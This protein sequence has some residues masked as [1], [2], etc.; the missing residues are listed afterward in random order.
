M[1]EGDLVI[2]IGNTLRGD[3]GVGWWLAERLEGQRPAA[4]EG[5]GPSI[6]GSAAV[7]GWPQVRTV[8]QLTPELAEELQAVRRVLFIDAWWPPADDS[9]GQ[10]D[11]RTDGTSPAAMGEPPEASGTRLI[12]TP[13][14]P[15]GGSGVAWIGPVLERLTPP[16]GSVEAGAFS[17][18]FDPSQLLAIGALLHA[19][20]PEAWRLLVPTWAMGHGE[21]FSPQ[22]QSLLPQA[23]ALLIHWCAGGSDGG[24][25]T[26]QL[27][28][29]GSCRSAAD[30]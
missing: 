3:D 29:L 15:A 25:T 26:A 28:E 22:L 6:A 5:A 13:I 12:G 24:A 2:G 16:D 11:A 30:A 21:G 18:Q 9:N 10:T 19:W 27:A 20:A 8:Q 17:H 7:N 14:G 4:E 1:A 23:E